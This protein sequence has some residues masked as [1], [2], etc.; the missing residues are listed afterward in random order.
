MLLTQI[1]LSCNLAVFVQMTRK[2]YVIR[3]LIEHKQKAAR[4]L[5]LTL[6]EAESQSWAVELWG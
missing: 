2:R 1:S 5:R 3:V 6:W 4:C